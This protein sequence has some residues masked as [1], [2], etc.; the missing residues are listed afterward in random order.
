LAGL[1]ERSSGPFCFEKEIGM[2]K[3][4]EVE[5]EVVIVKDRFGN[6]QKRPMR[7]DSWNVNDRAAFLD[8]LAATCNVK[9]SCEAVGKYPCSAYTLRRRDADF[10]DLWDQALETGYAALETILVE[11]ARRVIDIPIGGTADLPDP[12]HV[13]TELGLRLLAAY[14]KRMAGGQRAGRRPYKR[15]TEDDTNAEIL[16]RLR[17]LYRRAQKDVDK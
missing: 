7:R 8:H 5:P 1:E 14:Q 4:V 13:M 10:A 11:R 16:K 3:S 2:G 17:V 15:V 6:L 12:E 9:M